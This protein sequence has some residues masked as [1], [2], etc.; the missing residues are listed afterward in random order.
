MSRLLHLNGPPGIGKST[1]ARR[2]ATEHPGVLLLDLDV[3][4]GLLPGVPFREAHPVVRPLALAMAD[5]HLSS[6]RDVLLPQYLGRV[7][8]VERFETAATGAGA[9]FV[10]VLVTDERERAV[11]RFARRGADDDDPWHAQV[12]EFVAGLGGDDHL[13]EM[14]DALQPVLATRPSY[15]VVESREGELDATYDALLRVL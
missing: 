6:G 2:Y 10:D 3:L 13:R 4:C 12:R 7:S 14:Y 9:S 8:E 11:A 5:A 1:L 15:V